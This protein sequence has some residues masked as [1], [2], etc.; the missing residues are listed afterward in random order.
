MVSRESEIAIKALMVAILIE[1][2][3]NIGF[4]ASQAIPTLSSGQPNYSGFLTPTLIAPVILIAII[5]IGIDFLF[6]H[7]FHWFEDIFA[8]FALT[9]YIST[10]Q[11]AIQFESLY[12]IVAIL[13]LT[14]IFYLVATMTRTLLSGRVKS[15]QRLLSQA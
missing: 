3:L 14:F 15:R 12:G 1:A 8:P 10:A 9:F 4:L 11:P 7:G 13:S 2:L 6:M 5:L